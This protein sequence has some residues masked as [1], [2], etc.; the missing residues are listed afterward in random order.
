MYTFDFWKFRGDVTKDHSTHELSLKFDRTQSTVYAK[1]AG[2]TD[3]KIGEFIHWC[4]CLSLDP[5]DY[6]DVSE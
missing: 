1:L 6:I 2:K 3:L 5:I 4:N